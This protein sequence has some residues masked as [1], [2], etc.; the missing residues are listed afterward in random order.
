MDLSSDQLNDLGEATVQMARDL[1]T[2]V[3]DA[4]SISQIYSNMQS[5]PEEIV[6]TGKPTAIL[7]NL[8]GETADTAAN[9]IQSVMQ[10]FKMSE[11]EAMHIADVYDKISA[12]IKMDYAKGI[13]VI[14]AGTEAAGQTAAEAGLSFEQLSS[15]VAKMA[16]TTR[17]D[18]S[19]IGNALKTIMVRTSKAST[20]SD[21]VDNDTLSKASAALNQI[22]I[23]VYEL[24]GTYR[25]FDTIM[26]E[27]ADKWDTLTDA[28]RA[29][30][31]YNIAATRLA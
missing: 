2:S 5:T 1:N 8:A 10:Q 23:K 9:Q 12:N 11:D 21:E 14:A 13:E 17:E 16:E 25:S 18:G 15:I 22:G 7:A 27:L 28:Q 3:S 20:M 6:T 30:L 24:D 29:N 26:G 4:L 31:S 19:S